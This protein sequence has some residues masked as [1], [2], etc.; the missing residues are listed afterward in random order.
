MWCAGFVK[1]DLCNFIW[2]AVYHEDSERLECKNCS[3]MAYHEPSSVEEWKN[4]NTKEKQLKGNFGI[5]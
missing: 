3:N 4:V 5:V 1:C 2:L